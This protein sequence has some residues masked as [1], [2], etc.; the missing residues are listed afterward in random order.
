M[1]PDDK[2]LRAALKRWA[3][4]TARRDD[5][6]CPD[7]IRSTLRWVASH[8]RPVWVRAGQAAP[9]G[10]HAHAV[11]AGAPP[12]QLAIAAELAQQQVV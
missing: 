8:T 12:V 2:L 1:V 7:E 3:F 9:L 6:N 4:N 10:A 11:Q 5:P